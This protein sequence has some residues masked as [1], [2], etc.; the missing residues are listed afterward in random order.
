M[1]NLQWSDNCNDHP[2]D[3]S[4]FLNAVNT[5]WESSQTSL[6]KSLEIHSPTPPSMQDW[7]SEWERRYPGEPFPENPNLQWVQSPDDIP[8]GQYI[9]T[10]NGVLAPLAGTYP[11][12]TEFFGNYPTSSF[13]SDQSWSILSRTGPTQPVDFTVKS[14]QAYL[15]YH[16]SCV[17][18]WG[19]WS[20]TSIVQRIG[21]YYEIDYHCPAIASSYDGPL[22]RIPLGPTENRDATDER[23]IQIRRPADG[24]I[25]SN[26][27]FSWVHPT[28]LDEGDHTTRM[29]FIVTNTSGSVGSALANGFLSS[30]TQPPI[31]KDRSVSTVHFKMKWELV[32]L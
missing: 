1:F 2:G 12:K 15:V 6:Q 31:Y 29:G 32:Y 21:W 24:S 25:M 7:E 22:Q 30:T 10:P 9:N 14:G 11:G 18:F 26:F 16:L 20:P 3:I 27:S 17:I 19:A 28:P 4:E 23:L 8:M 5:V 13:A